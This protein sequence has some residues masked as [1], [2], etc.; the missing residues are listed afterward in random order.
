[1]S[2]SSAFDRLATSSLTLGISG[3]ILFLVQEWVSMERCLDVTK[4]WQSCSLI[5]DSLFIV[6]PVVVWFVSIVTGHVA[7][8]RTRHSAA[9]QRW[10]AIVGLVLSY[11]GFL[12]NFL[13]VALIITKIVTGGKSD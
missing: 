2:P 13:P 6:L 1:M 11:P 10:L 9:P 5:F 3:W 8:W 4:N 12:Y 7:F